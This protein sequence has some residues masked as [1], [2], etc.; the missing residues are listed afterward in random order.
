MVENI[1]NKKELAFYSQNKRNRT[2]NP[3]EALKGPLRRI[4]CRKREG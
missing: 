1:G 3:E 4:G 2:I